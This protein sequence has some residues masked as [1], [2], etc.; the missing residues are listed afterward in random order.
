MF[1]MVSGKMIKPMASVFTITQMEHVMKAGG[2][3]INNTAKVKKYGLIMLATRVSTK[4]AKNMATVNLFGQTDQ[5][6]QVN[7]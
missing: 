5:R 4:M 6:T 2:L 1:I 7:F 3:R